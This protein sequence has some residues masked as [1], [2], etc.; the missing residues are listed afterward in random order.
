MRTLRVYQVF[1][2][3]IVLCRTTMLLTG[4]GSLLLAPKPMSRME[5]APVV[6]SRATSKVSS[7]KRNSSKMPAGKLKTI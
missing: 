7:K 2:S 1:I 5:S 4:W 3:G 6:A